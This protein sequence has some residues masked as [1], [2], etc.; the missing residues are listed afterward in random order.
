MSNARRLT[1][2]A[3]VAVAAVSTGLAINGV[4]EG[5][6]L[7][8]PRTMT[9]TM[10]FGGGTSHQIDRGKKGFS[11]GD[12]ALSTDVPLRDEQTGHR[13]GA[14]DGIETIMSAAHNGTVSMSA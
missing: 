11:A 6:A 2:S 12:M 1:G 3:I 8:A 10:P 14:L 13:V 5:S 9:L 4:S 7:D